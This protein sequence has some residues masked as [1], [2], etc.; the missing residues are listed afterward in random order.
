VQVATV[1]QPL[2]DDVPLVSM[3]IIFQSDIFGSSWATVSRCLFDL[4]LQAAGHISIIAPGQKWGQSQFPVF[5]FFATCDLS[6]VE[7]LRPHNVV[8]PRHPC[9]KLIEV[10]HRT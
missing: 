7:K 1:S 10:D 8:T 9:V 4:T 2:L 5:N 3:G 6:E